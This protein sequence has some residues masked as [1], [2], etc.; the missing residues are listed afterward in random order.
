MAAVIFSLESIS[1]W[2]SL[3]LSSAPQLPNPD[4]TYGLFRRRLKGHLFREP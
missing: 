2:T 1:R 3:V 4:I